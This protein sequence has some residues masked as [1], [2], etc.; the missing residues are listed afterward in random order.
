MLRKGMALQYKERK[1]SLDFRQVSYR[2]HSRT[3]FSSL[4]VSVESLNFH[5]SV[6]FTS[7]DSCFLVSLYV[8]SKTLTFKVQVK[9]ASKSALNPLPEFEQGHENEV[10]DQR[11]GLY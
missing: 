4:L 2:T 6:P 1:I 10:K 9:L 8:S 5:I 3:Q 7:M 11:H